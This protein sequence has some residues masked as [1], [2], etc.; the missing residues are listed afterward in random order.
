MPQ[1]RTSTLLVLLPA[2]TLQQGS[3]WTLAPATHLARAWRAHWTTWGAAALL[4]P[5]VSEAC[6]SQA[7]EYTA[8]SEC[9]L[10]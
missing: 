5:L 3:T 4:L 6:G 2:R 1:T 8:V 7:E 9:R 10:S